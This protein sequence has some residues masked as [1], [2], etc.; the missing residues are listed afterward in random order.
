VGEVT[1]MTAESLRAARG[2]AA[3]VGG[4]LLAV[5]G[6]AGTRE[7]PPPRPA[8]GWAAGL[9]AA[10]S[11][12]GISR[13]ER[14]ARRAR[15]T[16][17]GVLGAAVWVGAGW[18]VAGLIAGAAVAGLPALFGGDR[19]ARRVISRL[20]A[21]ESWTRR[22]ADLRIAGGGL[23]QALAAS[24][25]ACPEPIRGEVEALAARLR[26]GWPAQ[27]A[28]RALADDMDEPAG[29]LVVAVLLEAERRG[30][31]V[32]RVLDDLAD[33]VA[34]E[35]LMRRRV[36]ADRA[37]PRTTARWVTAI[38]LGTVAVGALN[39]AYTAPYRTPLGQ[40]VLAAIAVAFGACLA[41]MRLLAQGRP[42]P[43][44][45]H[46]AAETGTGGARRWPR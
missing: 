17:A 31:G 12:P 30:A 46:D 44:F 43:R 9:A 35:V 42:E 32:A 13:R 1:A 34:E 27:A 2:G 33:T 38:T 36:E 14:A 6:M 4:L 7:P 11:P 3:L 15:W 10:W 40:L 19:A 39:T 21:L 16:A 29:D 23:E 5:A 45:L 18:P 37:K 25:R 24:A 8:P 41:W 20:E 22:L 28:L 26:A